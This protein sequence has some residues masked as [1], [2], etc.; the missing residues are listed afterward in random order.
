MV[1][2]SISGLIAN[3]V[4]FDTIHI[5]SIIVSAWDIDY[6]LKDI[7]YS[8]MKSDSTRLKMSSTK[9]YEIMKNTKQLFEIGEGKIVPPPRFACGNGLPYCGIIRA[10]GAGNFRMELYLTC[11]TS[12]FTGEIRYGSKKYVISLNTAIQNSL[13]E[14]IKKTRLT[15]FKKGRLWESSFDV[16]KKSQNSGK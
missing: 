11:P 15:I 7:N 2:F 1:L 9:F 16:L 8:S 13:R 12:D 10:Y 4:S 5:D 6:M 3:P 14:M